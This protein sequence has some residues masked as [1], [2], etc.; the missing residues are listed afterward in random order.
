[1]M[2]EEKPGSTRIVSILPEGTQVTKGQ[3][4]CQL[5]SSAFD[6]E[7]KVQLIRYAQAKSWLDQAATIL[8]VAQIS[9]R[10]YRDG[11]L[12]QDL[13]LIRQYITTCRIEKERAAQNLEWSRAMKQKGFR[14]TAQLKADGLNDQ[15]ASIALEEAQGMFERLDKFTGPK[16]LKSLEAKIKAIVADKKNQEASFELEKQRLARLQKCIDNCTLRAPGDG[17]LVYANQANRWGQVD[18]PI[19]QGVTVREGQ[20]IFQLPDPQHMRVKTRVN[21]TKVGLLKTG[22]EAIIRVDA[23]PER[24]LH[25]TVA[26]VT[27]I[28][29]PLNGPFSDVRIYYATVNIKEGGFADLRPG[30]TAEVLFKSS[31]KVGVTRVPLQAVRAIDGKHYVA[32]HEPTQGRE[33]GKASWRWKRIE[34]GLSDPDFVEVVSGVKRGDRVVAN[35]QKLPIP[36]A[37]PDEQ[38]G[39]PAVATISLQ[40]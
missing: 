40:P 39:A 30:L 19:E 3:L 2:E 13:Q 27:A 35:P 25:G 4:V 22:Q 1:M 10:E 16:I 9:Q 31:A 24:P 23:F 26:E 36:D 32:V 37:M 29:T 14:T 17:I 38:P 33:A 28:S 34:L 12:P 6:D 8:E 20:S 5:D 21:E 18:Q 11:I 7:L 15:Q